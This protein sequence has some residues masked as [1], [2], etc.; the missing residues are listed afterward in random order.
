VDL[1][2]FGNWGAIGTLLL[3]TG[4]AVISK[5]AGGWLGA[6]SLGGKSALMVGIGMVPRGEVGI[7]IAA[8]GQKAGVFGA[9][10]YAQIIAMSLLTSIV[11]PPI[12]AVLLKNSPESEGDADVGA[13]DISD[14]SLLSAVDSSGYASTV[15]DKET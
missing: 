10:I 3:I 1:S 14:E 6:L 11:A 12:L 7:I 4:L 13:D 9:S 5:L 15:P 2:Q 8:L